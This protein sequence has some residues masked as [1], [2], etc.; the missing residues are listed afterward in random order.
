MTP[1]SDMGAKQPKHN[2]AMHDGR[3]IDIL[4]VFCWPFLVGGEEDGRKVPGGDKTFK[5]TEIV[6][7]GQKYVRHRHHGAANPARI[8][9]FASPE[10]PKDAWEPYI[11]WRRIL[12]THQDLIRLKDITWDKATE[13]KPR[14]WGDPLP[15]PKG[16]V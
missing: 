5:Q 8:Y 4:E 15:K 3:E 9:Y 16:K 10:I 7:E 14:D 6:V 11:V 12:N 13:D 1:D 2:S